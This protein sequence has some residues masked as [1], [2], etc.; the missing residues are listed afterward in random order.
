MS[1]LSLLIQSLNFRLN[2]FVDL[3]FSRLSCRFHLTVFVSGRG[4]ASDHW[5][6][7]S[8]F[9]VKYLRL[10]EA[11]R[12]LFW[13]KIN[14]WVRRAWRSFSR[15]QAFGNKF[16]SLNIN[17]SFFFC[18]RIPLGPDERK[19]AYDLEEK[20]SLPIFVERYFNLCV[21]VTNSFDI[22]ITRVC[23]LKIPFWEVRLALLESLWHFRLVELRS[24]NRSSSF[25][26]V[27]PMTC[28]VCFSIEMRMT[29][30]KGAQSWAKLSHQGNETPLSAFPLR[31]YW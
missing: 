24:T 1:R 8:M 3:H 23:V 26:R 6:I 9:C 18:L 17:F 7:G 27:H 16:F 28:I 21:C 2:R 19:S 22:H 25:Q 30:D 10:Q 29:I 13:V 4:N 31:N 15:P 5:I 14:P 11:F 20:F 12:Q